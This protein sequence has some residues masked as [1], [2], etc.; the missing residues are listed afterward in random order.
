MLLTFLQ[1]LMASVLAEVVFVLDAV[2]TPALEGASFP[3]ETRNNPNTATPAI[4]RSVFRRAL[5]CGVE[6]CGGCLGAM[7]GFF[8]AVAP[9]GFGAAALAGPTFG[10]LVFNPPVVE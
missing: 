7:K 8:E 9:L 5:L 3:P 10:P 1:F 4:A 6:V 2:G